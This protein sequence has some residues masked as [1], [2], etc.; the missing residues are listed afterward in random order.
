MF[1]F[2]LQSF[3]ETFFF[4]YFNVVKEHIQST[5]AVGVLIQRRPQQHHV[6]LF[7]HMD[8]RDFS[9]DPGWP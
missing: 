8:P 7:L 1:R 6:L 5:A 9:N 3:F 2:A 4:L